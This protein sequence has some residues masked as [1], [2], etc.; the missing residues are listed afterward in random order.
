MSHGFRTCDPLGTH[1]L[2]TS[3]DWFRHVAQ[4]NLTSHLMDFTP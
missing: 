2:F 3:Y 1:D 4:L